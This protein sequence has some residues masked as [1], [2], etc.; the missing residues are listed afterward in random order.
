MLK[1][2]FTGMKRR[3]K[4]IRHV[5]IVTFLAVLFLSA[6]TL[7]QSITN[8]Y[9]FQKNLDT[10]GNWI[11]STVG[12][13]LEHPYLQV[14]S[15]CT[16][17]A[18]LVDE[19][20]NDMFLAMGK[21]DENFDLVDGTNLYEGRMPESKDE[22]T[23]DTMSLSKLGYSYELGQT[24]RIHYLDAEENLKTR[25]YKLVGVMKYFGQIWKTSGGYFLP[26]CFV[27]EEEF[28][29]YNVSGN[30]TYFYQLNP[31]Y[32]GIDTAEF[33]EHVSKNGSVITYNSYVYENRL[34][35]NAEIYRNVTLALMAMAALAISYL[36][37]AY[38]GKRRSIYYKYRCI[39]A[40]K[41][42]VR[43]IIFMECMYATFPEIILGIGIPYGIA[44]GI[45]KIVS[46]FY[47][48]TE[49]YEFDGKLLVIHI[50]VAVGVVLLAIVATQC[51]IRDKRLAGNTGTV[52]P[53]K[54]KRLRRIGNKTRKPERTIFK[55]QNAL[56]PVQYVV[57]VIF[58]IV[59][60][61]SLVICAY[62]IQESVTITQWTLAVKEDFTME[63]MGEEYT[64][65]S[66][67]EQK[68]SS[69]AGE[70]F[71]GG[72]T[73]GFSSYD[74]YIGADQ[75]IIG[76]IE[77]CPGVDTINYVIRDG[78][79]Y[80]EWDG[81]EESQMM[82]DLKENAMCDTPLEYKMEIKFFGNL[83]KIKKQM[84]TWGDEQQIQWDKYSEGEQVILIINGEDDTIKAGD[85]VRIKNAFTEAALSVEIGAVYYCGN[86]IWDNFL[87]NTYL[88]VGSR[89]LADKIAENEGKKLKYNTLE[90][91]YDRNASYES[92]DRQLAMLANDGGFRYRSEAEQRRIS[93]SQMVQDVGIYGTLFVMI[94]V[95]YIVIQR[96]FLASKNKYWQFRYTLLKQI[97]ME[98]RQYVKL[99][100][101]AECKSYLWLFAGLLPGY[102]AAGYM[103]YA[104]YGG[105]LTEDQIVINNMADQMLDGIINNMEHGLYIGMVV[106]LYLV[107][108]VSSAIVIRKCIKGGK[109]Q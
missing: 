107:M 23:M 9:L 30:T 4:E 64:F 51:S 14:E 43:Q 73:Y 100:L 108:T 92:T 102:V 72:D 8:N 15:S 84:K 86:E 46:H 63:K 104:K 87:T 82:K 34:W 18:E 29:G 49:F 57:S 54:Y 69:E 56:R 98:D 101:T 40:T 88:M 77:M 48:V 55:R 20:G 71:Y 6:I 26:N 32:N 78:L 36:M 106:L 83:T 76:N 1:L 35:G 52:K 65:P 16:T 95:I 67:E 50:F 96:S 42:Q 3:K 62:Q 59:V 24:I 103:Y 93:T 13:K 89:A 74:M 70:N 2:I 68:P 75:D 5:S 17:G 25:E 44:Y 66:K 33:A 90:I 47:G 61:G 60:C 81:I 19:Q 39:G 99:A 58:S 21:A 31:E 7:F 109:E 12:V 27:T 85:M 37:I 11:V 22:I 28:A 10:Y 53:S 97:G 45:C 94:L 105:L 38:T 91:I 79:H 41:N 80:F